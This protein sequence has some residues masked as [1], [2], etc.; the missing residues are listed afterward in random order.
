MLYWTDQSETSPGIYRTAVD[1]PAR[2]NVV[3]DDIRKPTAIAI[4]FI[5]L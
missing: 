5:G 3:T 1:E 4:D 2:E